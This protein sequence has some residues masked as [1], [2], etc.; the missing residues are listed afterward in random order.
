MRYFVVK[1]LVVRYLVVRYLVARYLVVRYLVVHYDML[2]YV[3]EYC[4]VLMCVE[5]W[6]TASL[7]RC[8]QSRV[9][10]IKP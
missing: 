6:P 10:Q 1:Y 2:Q 5:V 4:G 8:D 3:V 7:M 9:S